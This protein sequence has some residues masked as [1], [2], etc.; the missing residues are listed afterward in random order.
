MGMGRWRRGGGEQRGGGAF[1][2]GRVCFRLRIGLLRH[3]IPGGVVAVPDRFDA[4][5][6]T[7]GTATSGFLTYLPFVPG[8]RLEFHLAG[9]ATLLLPR[10][11]PCHIRTREQTKTLR[12]SSRRTATTTATLPLPVHFFF[13]TASHQPH[14]VRH[15]RAA[16]HHWPA[17]LR[18]W[19][20]RPAI[21]TTGHLP[22]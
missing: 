6:A 2:K 14:P 22:T 18:P 7:G 16:I 12:A 5:R 13:S 10:P 20:D 1:W 4:R 11:S 8:P 17:H 19:A 3:V 9:A 21:N 15:R